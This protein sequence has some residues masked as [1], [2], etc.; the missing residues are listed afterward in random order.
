MEDKEIAKQIMEKK[1]KLKEDK[2]ASAEFKKVSKKYR[3]IHIDPDF[4]TKKDKIWIFAEV[5]KQH[6]EKGKA[7]TPYSHLESH[8]F[9]IIALSKILND[10]IKFYFICDYEEGPLKQLKE[11]INVCPKLFDIPK[12]KIIQIKI[13]SG[14]I[15]IL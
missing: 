10:K 3:W 15:T 9:R 12:P 5:E 8:L 11:Y 14:R 6:Y 13:E 7:K 4:K 2:K 1:F